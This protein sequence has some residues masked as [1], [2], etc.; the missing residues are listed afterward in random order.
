MPDLVSVTLTQP[1]GRADSY[2][3]TESSGFTVGDLLVTAEIVRSDS[4]EIRVNGT[5][6]P[7]TYTLSEGDKVILTQKIKGA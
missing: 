2:T 3:L 7:S 6:V 5:V 1:P 4:T